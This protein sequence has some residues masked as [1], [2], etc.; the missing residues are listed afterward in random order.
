MGVGMGHIQ[1]QPLPDHKDM[2]DMVMYS[3]NDIIITII[4]V[5][6]LSGMPYDIYSIKGCKYS[7]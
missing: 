6:V 2:V 5:S 7:I 1:P 3:V 4:I